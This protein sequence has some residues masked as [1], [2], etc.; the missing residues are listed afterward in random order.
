MIQDNKNNKIIGN[1]NMQNTNVKFFGKNNIL[2]FECDDISIENTSIIFKG[3]NSIVVIRKS[4][5]VLKFN[6]T[7]YNESVIYVGKEC[8][9]NNKLELIASE[10]KNIIIGDEA[11]FS[12]QCLIRTSDAHRIYSIETL[13]RINEGRSVYLGDHIWLAARV[14][15]LK[16][17]KIH[18]GSIVGSDAVVAGKEILSNSIW[19]GN[20][21][22]QIKNNVFFEKTGT[23]GLTKDLLNDSMIPNEKIYKDYIYEND[24]SYISFEEV[25]VALNSL[26][27]PE[28]KL[29]KILSVMD[30]VGKNRFAKV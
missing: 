30:F 19:A 27:E 13:R 22:K 6:I 28:D 26:N 10:A 1:P 9:M 21:A 25:E 24:Q 11:L 23:H 20:P 15:L 14:V 12:S 5:E 17:T 18:S 2:Y 7:I 3:D 29:K 8:S 16:G 4:R